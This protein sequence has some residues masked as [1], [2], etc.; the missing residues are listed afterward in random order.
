[1][2]QLFPGR[3]LASGT[4][5]R[6]GAAPGRGRDFVSPSLTSPWF[7]I[8]LRTSKILPEQ[9][10]KPAIQFV[11]ALR[12][13]DA[14]HQGPQRDF[15]QLPLPDLDQVLVGADG[16]GNGRLRRGPGSQLV[17]VLGRER[18]V[19]GIHAKAGNV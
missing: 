17:M 6:P 18:M 5:P 10:L 16:R 11:A 4:S 13:L 3:C 14:N 8:P 2:R 1:M 12:H 19:I 9:P 15:A 7:S